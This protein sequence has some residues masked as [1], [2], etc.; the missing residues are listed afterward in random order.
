M[1]TSVDI[2][3]ILDFKGRYKF[4]KLQELYLKLFNKKFEGAHNSLSDIKATFEC[5]YE[6]LNRGVIELD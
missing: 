4:P 1:K 6:L 2:C 3:R 5:F